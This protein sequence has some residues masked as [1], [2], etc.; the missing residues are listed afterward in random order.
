[1]DE[2]N[3]LPPATGQGAQPPSPLTPQQ[4]ELCRRLDDW[5]AKYS[6]KAKPSDMFRGA[7][8]AASI[9]FRGNPDWMAQAANSL[10]EILYPFWSSQGTVADKKAEALKNSGS[11]R[12]DESVIQEVGRI[13]GSL[14]ELAHHGNAAGTSIDFDT[15]TPADFDRLLADF[16]RIMFAR[17]AHQ[18][19]IHKEADDI[20]SAG[21]ESIEI[22]IIQIVPEL[23]S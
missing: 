15:F 6:L 1:M 4:E 19:D 17:L 2:D 18:I 23:Q 22:P 7:V 20:L 8:F 3:T 13:Y 9:E 5:H 21:P 12:A 10:R 11:V 16:E 14:N